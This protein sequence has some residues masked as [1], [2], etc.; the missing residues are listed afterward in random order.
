MND[1]VRRLLTRFARLHSLTRPKRDEEPMIGPG[2]LN[3]IIDMAN[4][5]KEILE[6]EVIETVVGEPMS[7]VEF[8][9]LVDR[10]VSGQST[11]HEEFRKNTD[12]KGEN[13]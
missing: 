12:L 7:A 11:V 10:V 13:T 6:S 3:T 4:E 5:A 2:M 1:R 8:Y 9:N